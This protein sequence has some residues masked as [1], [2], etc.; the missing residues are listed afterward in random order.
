LAALTGK[1][2]REDGWTVEQSAAIARHASRLTSSADA[3]EGAVLAPILSR[4]L[5]IPDAIPRLLMNILFPGGN[6]ELGV[7]Q[8]DPESGQERPESQSGGKENRYA[9]ILSLDT[10][11]L[12]RLRVRLDYREADGTSRVGGT[13]SAGGETVDILIAGLPSLER[14]LQARGIMTDGFKVNDWDARRPTDSR[15]TREHPG[16][17]DIQA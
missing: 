7:M 11:G 12:G 13:F 5:E 15:I 8:I 6:A 9:G 1:L 3:F 2:A 17:L 10:P 14:S 4:S 16:G